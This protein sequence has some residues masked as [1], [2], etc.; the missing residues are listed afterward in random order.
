MEEGD[1]RPAAAIL[2]V[3]QCRRGQWGAGDTRVSRSLQV[4]GPFSFRPSCLLETWVVLNT[5]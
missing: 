1:P 2:R 3:R 5:L 4:E